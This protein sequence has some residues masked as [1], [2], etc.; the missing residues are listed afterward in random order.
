MENRVLRGGMIGA[1]AWSAT[2]LAAWSRVR[3]A[4]IVALCDRHP[5]RR[6]PAAARFGIP[7]VYDS[8][9]AMI[10]GAELDFVD[11]CTRPYSHAALI[12]QAAD[13]GLPVLCQKPFCTTL[14]E[15]VTMTGYCNKSGVR[16]M[17]NENFRWQAWFRKAAEVVATGVLGRLFFVRIHSR[18][19][20]TLPKFEHNQSYFTEMEQALLLEVGTHLLDLC[21]FLFGEPET[22]YART[23]RVSP[24]MKG[25]DVYALILGYPDMTCVIHD[26]WASVPVPDQELPPPDYPYYIRMLQ[27]DGTQGTLSQ[28]R[29]GA[30]HVYTD[31]DHQVY[32]YTGAVL[33]EANGETLQHFVDCLRSG[34]PFETSGADYIKTMALVHAAYRSA[35]E[36]Q[37]IRPSD[38]VEACT[39]T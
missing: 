23:H 8:L 13:R 29:D 2:Q 31:T 39:H 35:A 11:I 21:R 1:G 37:V 15:A 25:E 36:G 16:L 38:L 7:Q 20:L 32:S 18:R 28:S 24:L 27:V 12:Q 9:K 5:E 26:S 4:R 17:V 14:Q 22:V 3:G 6:D 34:A 33:P 19:R 30:L 10:D